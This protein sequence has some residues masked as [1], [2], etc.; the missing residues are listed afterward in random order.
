MW[1]R[2]RDLSVEIADEPLEAWFET[3][4]PIWS[5]ELAIRAFRQAIRR[6]RRENDKTDSVDGN[7]GGLCDADQED[8]R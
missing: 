1:L 6:R 4:H 2:A 3:M 8:S 7:E 5:R